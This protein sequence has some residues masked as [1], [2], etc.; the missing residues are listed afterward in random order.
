VHAVVRVAQRFPQLKVE[1]DESIAAR[2][3]ERQSSRAYGGSTNT[4]RSVG[5]PRSEDHEIVA[6]DPLARDK[7]GLDLDRRRRLRREVNERR[8]RR[9]RRYRSSA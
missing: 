4:A 2:L 7:S 9:R 6:I 1:R 5:K 8:R 3:R